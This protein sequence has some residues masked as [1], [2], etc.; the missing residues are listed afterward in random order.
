MKSAPELITK[1]KQHEAF[2]EYAYPDPA[3]PLARECRKRGFKARWGFEPAGPIIDRLPEDLKKFHGNPWTIGYGETK[4]ITYDMRWSKDEAHRRL[5][6]RLQEF[7]DGVL[8]ACT[9]EPNPN[10]CAALVSFAYNVGVGGLKKSSVLR[11]HNAGNKDAAARAFNL[12]TK[13]GGQVLPGLVRRRADEAALYLKPYQD[14]VEDEE[15]LAEYT[16]PESQQVEPERP[17]TQSQITRAGAVAGGTAAVATVAETLSTVNAVKS[18]VEGLG[19]WLV[20]ILLI[21]TIAAVGYAVWQ[22]YKQREGGW[23]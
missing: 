14:I 21:V 6:V 7:E 17:M 18:G 11:N 15:E 2:R 10:E 19:Q 5:L 23:A 20:P 1:V 3:S 16:E 12:W 13:A 4:G 9:R 22:R 8:A